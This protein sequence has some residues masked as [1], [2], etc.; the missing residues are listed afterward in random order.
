MSR[1]SQGGRWIQ[2]GDGAHPTGL[3]EGLVSNSQTDRKILEGFEQRTSF[4]CHCPA[5]SQKHPLETGS[6][7]IQQTLTEPKCVNH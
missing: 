1:A 5:V 7:S 3:Q 2:R 4:L 6:S